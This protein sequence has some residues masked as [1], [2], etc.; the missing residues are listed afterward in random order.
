MG[1]CVCVLARPGSL[2]HNRNT[3]G[4]RRE[5]T[6]GPRLRSVPTLTHSRSASHQQRTSQTRP[7]AAHLTKPSQPEDGLVEPRVREA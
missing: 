5:S 6:Q 1:V 3:P 7:D 4:S 2:A